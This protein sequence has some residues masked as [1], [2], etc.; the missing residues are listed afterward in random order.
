MNLEK[1]AFKVYTNI[2]SFTLIRAS[3]NFLED[4]SIFF[5]NKCLVDVSNRVRNQNLEI[6]KNQNLGE[7][8][9]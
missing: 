9:I 5:K 8:C 3:K 6:M 1:Y 4:Q 7:I 2:Q